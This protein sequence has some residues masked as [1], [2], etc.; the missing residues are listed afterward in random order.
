MP[1]FE[2]R[3]NNSQGVLDEEKGLYLFIKADNLKQAN[4]AFDEHIL[5][6]DDYPYCSCCGDRWPDELEED[7]KTT[8]GDILFSYTNS[9]MRDR[10][11]KFMNARTGEIVSFTEAADSGAFRN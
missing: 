11:F 7:D 9:R 4:D 8:T 5:E 1:W 6:K 10:F 2:V 3:Q